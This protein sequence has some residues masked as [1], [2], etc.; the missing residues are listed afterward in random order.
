MAV[1]LTESRLR[2]IIREEAGRLLREGE[3]F[4]LK[5]GTP[6]PKVGDRISASSVTSGMSD[7][8]G[9]GAERARAVASKNWSPIGKVTANISSDEVYEAWYDLGGPHVPGGVPAMDLADELGLDSPDEIPWAGTGLRM[10]DGYV[11]EMV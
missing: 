10:M 2:Q 4:A 7:I 6:M 3:T 8:E 1:K 5:P 11:D 9:P